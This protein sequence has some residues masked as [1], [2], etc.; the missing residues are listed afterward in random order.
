M[1]QCQD[2]SGFLLCSK[3]C[4]LQ[5]HSEKQPLLPAIVN[6]LRQ[7]HRNEEAAYLEA[8]QLQR[9][10]GELVVCVLAHLI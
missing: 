5:H 7:Q 9:E 1:L 4:L 8:K 2:T 10:V 6:L 3:C